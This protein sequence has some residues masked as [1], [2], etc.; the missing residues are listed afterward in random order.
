MKRDKSFL[1]VWGFS[2]LFIVGAVLI[3]I[4]FVLGK[5]GYERTAMCLILIPIFLMFLFNNPHS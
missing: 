5:L 1:K 2:L 4:G 3:G